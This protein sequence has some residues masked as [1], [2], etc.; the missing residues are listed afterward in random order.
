MDLRDQLQ[1]TLGGAYVIEHELKSGGM[2]RDLDPDLPTARIFLAIDRALIGNRDEARTILGG[3]LPTT[4]WNGMSAYVFG[5]IGDTAEVRRI[6]AKLDSL[7]RNTWM[8]NTARAFAYLGV[9]KP[10]SALASLEAAA[11][12]RETTP[13]W[14]SLSNRDLDPVRGTPRFAAVV[15]AFK[16]DETNLTSE[17]GARLAP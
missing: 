15:R 4:P 9:G 13:S 5:K 14:M 17:K 16:L 8:I 11:K 12:A 6:M 2:A 1:Q 3:A 7:P 10:D